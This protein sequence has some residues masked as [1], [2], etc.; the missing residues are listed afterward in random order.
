[1]QSLAK[2]DEYIN[3]Q[4]KQQL[5][6][7]FEVRNEI[8]TKLADYVKLK[9]V[10]KALKDTGMTGK[11]L[12]MQVDIGDNFYVHA[13]VPDWSTVF[14]DIGYGFLLELTPEETLKFAAKK[15]ELLE[16]RVSQESKNIARLKARIKILTF[17]LG[18]KHGMNLDLLADSNSPRQMI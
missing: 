16:S 17:G 10:L 14:V 5:R 2:V 18:Q 3:E 9:D 1:M 6:A 13:K 4:L 7:A 15:I 12:K 11:P 8:V